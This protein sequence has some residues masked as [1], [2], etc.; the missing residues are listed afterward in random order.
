[1]NK[2]ITIDKNYIKGLVQIILNNNHT[3]DRK[4]N[5]REYPDRLSISCPICGDS[6]KNVSKKRG[7]LY[8][9]NM[10][11]MCFNEPTCSRSFTRLLQT[12]NVEMDLN[13]KLELYDYIDNNVQFKKEDIEITS[14]NKLFD[15]NELCEF[16]SKD[17]TRGITELKPLEKN[18]PVYYHVKYTRKIPHHQHIYQGYYNFT[19]KWKQPVMVFLNRMGDKVISMQVRNLL[20]GDKRYFKIMDFSR[21]YDLMYPENENDINEQER[22]SYDKLSHFFNIFNVDFTSKINLFEGYVDSIFLPNS[23]G[24]IGVNTDISF[25]LKEDGI[26]IRFIYDNDKSGFRK[27]EQMLEEGYSVFLWNKLFIDLLKKH[28]GN[29]RHMAEKLIEITD[30]NKLALNLKKPIYEMFDLDKYFSNDNL[31]KMYLLRL[32]DL[33]SMAL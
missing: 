22:I 16:F 10:M 9:K 7:N 27:T 31:D 2:E 28:K 20:D 24:Q 19:S 21:I 32:T 26:D 14:L 23:I 15:I 13:K 8:W 17:P 6:M 1:M 30:F 3:D 18:S 4:K 25:L 5:I 12:F 29:K 11:Y 33:I